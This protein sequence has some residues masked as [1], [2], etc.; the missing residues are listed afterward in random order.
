VRF[1]VRN[2]VAVLA[3][4]R[5]FVVEAVN[6]VLRGLIF[7]SQLLVSR[8]WLPKANLDNFHSFVLCGTEVGS[9]VAV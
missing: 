3:M 6:D 2:L 7:G 1:D 9:D 4:S 5:R 8:V